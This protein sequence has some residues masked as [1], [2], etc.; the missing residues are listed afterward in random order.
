VGSIISFSLSLQLTNAAESTGKAWI[1]QSNRY[2]R[3]LFDVQ[4][5]HSPEQGSTEGLARFDAQISDPRVADELAQRRELEAVLNTRHRRRVPHRPRRVFF[6]CLSPR[7]TSCPPPVDRS[8]V[9]G[10][11]SVATTPRSSLCLCYGQGAGDAP[12]AVSVERA[13]QPLALQ[14]STFHK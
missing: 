12:D 14:A 5:K 6:G 13:L 7:R 8:K 10:V 9:H 11:A 1:E 2:T 3:L 4:L